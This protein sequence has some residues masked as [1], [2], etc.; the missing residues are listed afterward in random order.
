MLL[1]MN[2]SCETHTTASTS[3]IAVIAIFSFLVAVKLSFTAKCG[4]YILGICKL[5]FA[6]GCTDVLIHRNYAFLFIFTL[7]FDCILCE[8]EFGIYFT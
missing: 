1:L 4:R 8:S 2:G 6:S 5:Y 7:L 3:T